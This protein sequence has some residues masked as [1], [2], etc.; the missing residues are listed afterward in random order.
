MRLP[1]LELTNSGLVELPGLIL[2]GSSNNV[3][4]KLAIMGSGRKAPNTH[5]ELAGRILQKDNAWKYH[6]TMLHM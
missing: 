4:D 1:L 6:A 3:K 5:V 2:N